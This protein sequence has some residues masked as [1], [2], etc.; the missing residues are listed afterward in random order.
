MS[1]AHAGHAAGG[2]PAAAL[3]PP[4]LFWAYLAAALRQRDPG[5]AGWDH[6]RTASFA[7]GAA[8]LATRLLLPAADLPG[9]MAQHLVLGM[10]A[11]LALVL[12]APG[13]L[14]LRT[15]DRRVGRAAL[16]LLRH[17][18]LQALAH[19]VT[20]LL[21]TAGGLWLL[22]LTPLYRA[23][24]TQP[25]LHGLVL[26]HFVLSG[27]LFT[28]SIAGPD[29]GPHRP[30]VPIRLVVLGLGVAAHAV[31]AQLLYAGLLVDVPATGD[32]LRAGATVMYYGG[33]LAEILLALALLVTWRPERA[34]RPVAVR[35]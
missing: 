2:F 19:P 8:L 3:V 22:Y 25:A 14:A 16:R 4:V 28:W 33:D 18:A 24:L 7:L 10:L 13:T 32:E 34:P 35:A 5:R 15:V 23:T 17:P 20:G 29:P 12:G 31:L 1:L 9:H 27:Y 11:P 6:R 30:R 26:L 21:L